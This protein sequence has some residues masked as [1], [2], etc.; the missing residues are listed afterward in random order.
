MTLLYLAFHEAMLSKLNLSLCSAILSINCLYALF[1]SVYIF[2]ET[3][4]YLQVLGTF[5]NITGVIIASYF[6]ASTHASSLKMLI[7]TFIAATLMGIWIVLSR[8]CIKRVDPQ[9]YI[10]LNFISEFIYGLCLLCLGFTGL[11]KLKWEFYS[12]LMYFLFGF[13]ICLAE[14]FLFLSLSRGPVGPVVSIVTSNGILVGVFDSVLYG[15]LPSVVQTV[16]ILL[17]FVGIV[18]LSS[19]DMIYKSF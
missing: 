11:I 7:F 2:K 19:G 13:L 16:G 14:I 12:D 17:A 10:T 18:V 3:I 8:Y 1:A 5:I 9:I 15:V 6:S 4:S